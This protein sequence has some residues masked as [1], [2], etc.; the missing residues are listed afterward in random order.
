[1][2]NKS[3]RAK[4][5]TLVALAFVVTVIGVIA[6]A[7]FLT[8][9]IIREMA[10]IVDTNQ[11][12]LYTL[13]LE[14]I[15]DKLKGTFVDLQNTLKETGLTGTTMAQSYEAEAQENVLKALRQQYYEGQKI[16][17]RSVYFFITDA[18]GTVVL[19]PELVRGDRSLAQQEFMK[20]M[21]EAKERTF[22]YRYKDVEKWL[23]VKK[24]EPWRWTVGFAVP[25]EIKYAGFDR[26]KSLL[27]GFRNKQALMIIGLAVMVIIVLAVFITR[28]VT[29]PIQH[30]VTGLNRGADQVASASSQV[31]SASQSLASGASEQAASIE[32]TS[33]SLQEM[34][35]MTK[36][37]ALHAAEADKLVKEANQI[38]I[39]ANESMRHLTGSME[40]ISS[41][42]ER[43][44]K[45]V[46]TID[47]IAFQTNLLAL[48]AAVEAARAGEAGAG[49][50]VVADEVRKLAMRAAEA[51]K[52]TAD[53]IEGTVKKVKEGSNFV[54]QTNQAFSTV[55]KGAA[56]IESL[57]GE[58]AAASNEQAQGIEEVNRAASEMN[59]AVQ[60]VASNAEESASVSE[61]MAA[62]A[63]QMKEYVSGLIALV[64][65]NRDGNLTTAS[66]EIIQHTFQTLREKKRSLENRLNS[67]HRGEFK[68]ESIEEG[69]SE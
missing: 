31:S 62:Q 53:L 13:R 35:S 29:Q 41:A 32:E 18:Q 67:P 4:L 38:V 15:I 3:I 58:I 22:S 52:N 12:E 37:N 42:S 10:G 43:T 59:R 11:G 16:D 61:E 8:G 26:V 9:S 51:A 54:N 46:K 69:Q 47:E 1:M 23:F 40:E 24:F 44:S 60:R 14:G 64:G 17:N 36:Q 39:Q 55:A 5:L 48:N 56:K 50:A 2:K 19:H 20:Q 25:E 65:A 57:I 7:T 21:L 49:F 27:L 45:I 28:Y 30:A 33:S 6:L 66:K 63:E 34:A 68:N